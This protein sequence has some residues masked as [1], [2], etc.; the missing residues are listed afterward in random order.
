MY[1]GT[2]RHEKDPLELTHSVSL[3]HSSE[4]VNAAIRHSS[5]SARKY[6]NFIVNFNQIIPLYDTYTHP[7]WV[8]ILFSVYT[9]YTYD[10][11]L[12]RSSKFVFLLP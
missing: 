1:P 12:K 2:H 8:K 3:K 11:D 6:E 4:P 9:Y 10:F 5:T 7:F